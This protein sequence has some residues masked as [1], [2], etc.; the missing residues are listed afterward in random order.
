MFDK[1]TYLIDTTKGPEMRT[2]YSL[3]FKSL[4][5]VLVVVILM[6]AF[7]FVIAAILPKQ[8]DI[9][10][11]S[12]PQITVHCTDANYLVFQDLEENYLA[13]IKLASA[14]QVEEIKK[15]NV[16]VDESVENFR[17]CATD[18]RY[19]EIRLDGEIVF[20]HAKG[21]PV[22]AKYNYTLTDQEESDALEASSDEVRYLQKELNRIFYIDD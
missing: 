3:N 11:T 15:L 6:A 17:S 5:T 10:V 18:V 16:I 4:L 2:R 21:V 12:S 22:P 7:A 9:P 20:Y 14:E 13:Y 19:Y 1:T 8:T